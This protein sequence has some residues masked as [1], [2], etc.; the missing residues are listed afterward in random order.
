MFKWPSKPIQKISSK[1]FRPTHCPHKDCPHHRPTSPEEFRYTY[2]GFYSRD[3]DGK[4]VQRFRCKACNRTFSQQTFSTT[5]WLKRPDLLE[6]IAAGTVAG[7][8]MRQIARSLGCHHST[9][10]RHSARIGRHCMLLHC[11]VLAHLATL[12]EAIAFDHFETFVYSQNDR[13]GVTTPVGA[14]SWF[15]YLL[16]V[17]PHRRSGRMSPFQKKKLARRRVPMP[18]VG[19]VTRSCER[20]L[21]SLGK[22]VPEGRPIPFR[23]DDH[24]VYSKVMK[25]HPAKVRFEH[26]VFGN[27]ERG[28][29]GSPRSEEARKRDKALFPVDA[30]HGL[31]RHSIANHKRETLAFSR[32]TNALYERLSQMVVWRNMIKWRSERKPDPRT[33]AMLL[34]LTDKPWSWERVLS[35]RLFPRRIPMPAEWMELYQREKVTPA[36]GRNARHDLSMAF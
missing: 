36:V 28:P 29:K 6:P 35:Q 33:P 18:D 20:V 10:Q 7:S 3:C 17:A 32:R 11:Q 30:L 2:A 19:E 15:V 1:K 23:T 22:M 21:D 16:E 24:P 4:S 26:E 27:P 13:V 34:G 14:T 12:K 5:Y 8:A 31:I 9:V 25:T